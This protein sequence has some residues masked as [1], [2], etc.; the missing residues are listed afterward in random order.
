MGRIC[1]RLTVGSTGADQG[2][3][4]TGGHQAPPCLPQQPA[5][6]RLV[7]AGFVQGV[8]QG[9]LRLM[10]SYGYRLPKNRVTSKPTC[11]GMFQVPC[12]P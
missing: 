2:E 5:S 7:A 4:R 11:L 8:Q 9:T 3:Q 12:R 10:N 1:R 6:A